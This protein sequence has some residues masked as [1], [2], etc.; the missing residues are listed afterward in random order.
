MTTDKSAA[1]YKL[2]KFNWI[3]ECFD[4]GTGGTAGSFANDLETELDL[5]Q[6]Q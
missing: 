6:L 5:G 3:T 1:E 2:Y 4:T